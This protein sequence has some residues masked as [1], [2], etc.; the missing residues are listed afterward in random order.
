MRNYQH[1]W[2]N[3]LRPAPGLVLHTNA[4]RCAH[5]SRAGQQHQRGNG[6]SHQAPHTAVAAAV[7]AA[8][9]VAA[10]A[11]IGVRRH[12]MA[13]SH[14]HVPPVTHLLAVLQ[15][16]LHH[17]LQ[18]RLA[19]LRKDGERLPHC[20]AIA[21]QQQIHSRAARLRR[22]FAAVANGSAIRLGR[23]P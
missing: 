19:I 21:A 3:S 23:V 17:G 10:S 20:H 15:Q 18:L 12:R 4:K 9:A 5:P 7:T 16:V 11:V 14:L 6:P 1:R 22:V 13:L 2:P 8:V